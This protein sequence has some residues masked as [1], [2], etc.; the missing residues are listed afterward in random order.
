MVEDVSKM[1]GKILSEHFIAGFVTAMYSKES[2]ARDIILR[3][4][5]YNQLDL[6]NNPLICN[7][8]LCWIM[9]PKL[10]LVLYLSEF[11]CFS[12]TAMRRTHRED[13]TSLLG[14]GK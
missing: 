6:T 7:Q 9:E 13:L 4:I 5:P 10:T 1:H 8:N 11:P 12:P 2:T 3:D 14:C